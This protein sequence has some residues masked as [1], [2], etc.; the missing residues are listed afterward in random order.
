MFIPTQILMALDKYMFTDFSLFS[1][2]SIIRKKFLNHNF[3][4]FSHHPSAAFVPRPVPEGHRPER[5]GPV[6]L[7][8]QFS[9]G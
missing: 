1:F 6:Q 2:F 4:L 8:R 9:A 5:F 7:G 3:S